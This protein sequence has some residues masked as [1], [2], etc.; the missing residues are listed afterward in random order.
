MQVSNNVKSARIAGG[1]AQDNAALRIQDA[2][3]F[4]DQLSCLDVECFKNCG[5]L[6]QLYMPPNIRR[7]DDRC[8]EGCAKLRTVSYNAYDKTAA[9]EDGAPALE[10]VGSRAFAGCGNVQQLVLPESIS[11]LDQ[12]DPQALA[13]SSITSLTLLGLTAKQLTGG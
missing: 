7:I 2:A 8:F 3:A 13:G 6:Q 9:D 11:S 1:T 12:L 10:Y 4:G 5:E